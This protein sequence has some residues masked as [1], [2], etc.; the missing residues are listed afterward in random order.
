M[1][2]EGRDKNKKYLHKFASHR[3]NTNTILEIKDEEGRTT[4]MFK[5][6]TIAAVDHFKK[7]LSA[8]PGC[9]ISEILEVL[10]LFPKLITEE[11]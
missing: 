11:M 7:I 8:P 4:K 5:E 2:L 10:N 9:P 3:K 1:W 6:K